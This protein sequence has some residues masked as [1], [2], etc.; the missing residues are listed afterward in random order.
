MRFSS[1][2]LALGASACSATPDAVAPTAGLPAAYRN[3]PSSDEA[4][5]VPVDAMWWKQLRD[6]VLDTLVEDALRDSLSI[7]IAAARLEQA[8]AGLA[9]SD[10]ARAPLLAASASVDRQ[11]ATLED[12]IGRFASQVPGY[13]RSNTLFGLGLAASWELD[14]FGRLAA[15]SRAA[16]ADAEAAASDVSGA[17]LTVAAEIAEAYV[18]ARELQA[19]LK[20]AEERTETLAQLESIVARRFS[21]GSAARLELDQV[22]TDRKAAEAATPAIALA[23]EAVLNRIDVLS[24]RAPGPARQRLGDAPIPSAPL[25]AVSDA[26]A[27]SLLMRPDLVAASRRVAAADARTAQAL[28]DRLP[29]VSLSALFGLLSAGLSNLIMDDAVQSSVGVAA[30][31]PILDFGRSKAG[32]DAARARTRE[33]VGNYRLVV[34]GAVAEVENAGAAL[35]QRK[36]QSALLD[37]GV[38]SAGRARDAARLAYIAGS[39]SLIEALDAE[40]RLLSAEDAAALARADAARA[41]IATFRALGGGRGSQ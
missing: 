19:R 38:V 6:P 33:A 28:A 37:S 5:G 36:E 30:S 12:P 23:L 15:G 24:G 13:K 3:L 8:A 14:L 18:T 32:F 1:F 11:S 7:E 20:I 10:A 27:A 41:A 34:L 22:Q 4:S 9:A 16:R 31:A 29:R 40:R 25:I 21:A 39:V 2:I 17:R 26:P 35:N